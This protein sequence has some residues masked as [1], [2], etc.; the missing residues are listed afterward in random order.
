MLSS[1]PGAGEMVVRENRLPSAGWPA[2][3]GTTGGKRANAKT[4]ATAGDTRN[5]NG[6]AAGRARECCGGPKFKMG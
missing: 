1:L 4:R 5:G 2:H 6:T 3:A